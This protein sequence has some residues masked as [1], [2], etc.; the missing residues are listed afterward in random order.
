M[1]VCNSHSNAAVVAEIGVGIILDLLKKLSYH[2]RKM[3]Q[4]NWNRDQEPLDLK[5]KM[6]SQQKVCIIGYG[7]IGSKVGKYLQ[8]FGTEILAVN[9]PKL[10]I[11]GIQCFS[12]EEIRKAVAQADI[13]V[14]TVP[15]T[16]STKEMVNRSFIDT[17]KDGAFLVTLSRAG[18]VDEDALYEALVSEKL[19]GYGS[20]VWWNTPKR[21]E[22]KSFVSDHNR[23][24]ELDQVVL[25]PHRA[26]FS[27]N[28]L[29]HLDDV[30]VNLSNLIQGRPLINVVK[31]EEQY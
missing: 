3:R 15:L 18:I 5:S 8:V 16:D 10:D 26:G 28:S 24:E 22:N 11:E 21:G 30:V 1:P 14:L 20:D 6:L 17:M 2:D 25:S 4:G 12:T 7:S 13:V 9:M 23:F 29:P 31:M 27:E 19:A